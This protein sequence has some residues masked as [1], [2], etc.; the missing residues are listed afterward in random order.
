MRKVI[1]L[2]TYSKT[3]TA[4]VAG[5]YHSLVGARY[6]NPLQYSCLEN[7]H[8]QRSL[9]GYG[10]QGHKELD[11]TEWLSTAHDSLEMKECEEFP[12]TCISIHICEFLIILTMDLLLS[13][14]LHFSTKQFSRSIILKKVIYLNKQC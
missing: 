10:P 5:S 2:I 4:T 3:N 6:G 13:W 7:P 9:A 8:E 1:L 12:N 14:S 11:T